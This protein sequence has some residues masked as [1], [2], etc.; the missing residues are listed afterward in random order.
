MNN[1]HEQ[2]K[3][4]DWQTALYEASYRYS[5][6]VSELHKANPWPDNPVLAQAISTL[7]TDLWDRSFSVTEII[8]AFREAVANL[9]PYAAG[10]EVRP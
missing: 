8:S 10:D 5:L 9:P 4:D 6:A 2:A 1:E 7:A 3:R